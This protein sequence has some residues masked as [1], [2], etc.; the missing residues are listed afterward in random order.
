MTIAVILL[1]AALGHA[2]LDDPLGDI[3]MVAVGYLIGRFGAWEP[4]EAGRAKG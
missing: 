4:P 1:L 2:R 3:V